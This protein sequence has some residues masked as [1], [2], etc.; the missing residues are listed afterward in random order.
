MKFTPKEEREFKE[1]KLIQPVIT[2]TLGKFGVTNPPSTGVISC[3]GVVIESFMGHMKEMEK[4]GYHYL[5]PHDRSYERSLFEKLVRNF[6]V[7]VKLADNVF[8]F[9]NGLVRQMNISSEPKANSCHGMVM[10]K[11]KYV[12]HVIHMQY[13]LVNKLSDTTDLELLWDLMEKLWVAEH[14]IWK[15]TSADL[16][17]VCIKILKRSVELHNKIMEEREAKEHKMPCKKPRME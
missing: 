2:K 15:L 5:G 11:T 6:K 1:W 8:H 12:V 17:E 16:D 14:P 9:L 10:M 3:P 13:I 4:K 7:D